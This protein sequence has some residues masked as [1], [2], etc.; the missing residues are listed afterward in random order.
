[1]CPASP[2]PIVDPGEPTTTFQHQ[3]LRRLPFLPQIM[4]PLLSTLHHHPDPTR[5][6]LHPSVATTS[7]AVS[8]SSVGRCYDPS[9]QRQ[10]PQ[11][12]SRLSSAFSFITG[13][14]QIVPYPF[15]TS[16]IASSISRFPNSSR[17]HPLVDLFAPFSTNGLSP[18]FTSFSTSFFV[19][20]SIYFSLFSIY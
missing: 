17:V 19:R 4:S 5:N 20:R 16:S 9:L 10:R 15:T 11:A 12:F 14:G 8:D 1:M 6:L 2:S 18:A 13:L 7:M 3:K